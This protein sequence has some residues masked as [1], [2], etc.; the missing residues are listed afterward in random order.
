[1]AAPAAQGFAVAA[2]RDGAQWRVEALPPTVLDD[3]GVLLAALRSQPPEGGPFVVACVED[4]FFVIARQ[5]GKRL[6]L[7]LSDLTAAVEFPLAEQVITRLGEDPPADDELDEVWPV[8]DLDLFDDLDLGEDEMED[9][10]D[11]LDALP[12]EMLDSIV[13]QLGIADA[14]ARATDAA[15]A[16]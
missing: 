5:E 4:E 16:R 9:I 13:D 8:G 15:W 3:L 12:E 7:L 14:F 11:D 1:M 6:S 10:L 2:F